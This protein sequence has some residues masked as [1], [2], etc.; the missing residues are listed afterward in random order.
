MKN[1]EVSFHVTVSWHY[2]MN[3]HSDDMVISKLLAVMDGDWTL[4]YREWNKQ[5]TQDGDFIF[6]KECTD[7]GK[8][9]AMAILLCLP[10]LK[11][12]M[13]AA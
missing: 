3:Q 9:E 10:G 11:S 4:K 2:R 12:I 1:T 6:S 13:T 5:W 8:T 7:K